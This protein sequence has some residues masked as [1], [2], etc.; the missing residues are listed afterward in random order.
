MKLDNIKNAKMTMAD[1]DKYDSKIVRMQ[2]NLRAGHNCRSNL[3][4]VLLKEKRTKKLHKLVGR[5]DHIR[6]H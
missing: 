3:S 4:L 2:W 1:G 6:K 5:Y